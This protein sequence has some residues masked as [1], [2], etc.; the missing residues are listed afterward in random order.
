M[1]SRAMSLVVVSLVGMVW[2][3]VVGSAPVPAANDPLAPL[4]LAPAQVEKLTDLTETFTRKQIQSL[5]N[6]AGKLIELEAEL[7]RPER[8]ETKRKAGQAAKRTNTIVKQIAA[9]YGDM[10]KTK[11]EY[12]LAAKDVL[13]TEQRLQLL[14][15][16]DFNVDLPDDLTFYDDFDLLRDELDLSQ[17]QAKKILR[18]RMNMRVR[19]LKLE[20]EIDYKLLDLEDEFT[21]SEIDSGAVNKTVTDMA[22]IAIKMLNNRVDHFLRAKDELT[23]VQKRHLLSMLT[24][25]N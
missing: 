17:K 2:P 20:L 11:V 23:V 5:A 6:I 21:E 15:G 16:L 1:I 3:S 19:E 24:A 8:F 10:F 9:L 12:V 4:N 25:G 14:A 18:H 22:E 13:T 7:E